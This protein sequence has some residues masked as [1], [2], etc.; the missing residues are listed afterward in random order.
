MLRRVAPAPHTHAHTPTQHAPRASLAHTPWQVATTWRRAAR[1][2]PDR[3]AHVG[4]SSPA[5]TDGSTIRT[6]PSPCPCPASPSPATATRAKSKLA[7]YGTPAAGGTGAATAAPA[8]EPA[9]PSAAD[10]TPASSPPSAAARAEPFPAP[11]LPKYFLYCHAILRWSWAPSK[12]LWVWAPA[13][14]LAEPLVPTAPPGPSLL[15]AAAAADDDDD[16]DDGKGRVA[17]KPRRL[18][19][20]APSTPTTT[21]RWAAARP[22]AQYRAARLATWPSE[23]GPDQLSTTHTVPKHRPPPSMASTTACPLDTMR[24]P[25]IQS[26]VPGSA[27]VGAPAAPTLSTPGTVEAPARRKDD[28]IN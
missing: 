18:G 1:A 17:T 4:G 24:C 20:P 7:Q 5:S 9:A 14:A 6:S 2:A 27:G 11:S 3:A 19:T 28:C 15:D 13:R 12:E 22:C 25:C 10:G 23:W 26:R 8:G 16:D 21:V